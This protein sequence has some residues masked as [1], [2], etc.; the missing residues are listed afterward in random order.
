MNLDKLSKRDPKL[1]GLLTQSQQWQRLDQAI[2]LLS[3]PNLRAH[4][5]VACIEDGCLV[6]IAT[7]SMAAG[8]LRMILPSLLPQL[9]QVD[10]RIEQV[11][12]K[13]IPTPPAPPKV[14]NLHF[15]ESAL[16]QFAQTAKQLQ[17]HPELAEA[18]TKL[19]ERNR[20]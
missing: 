2:K 8:R 11:R 19:V 6:L 20:K 16:K 14:K 17:H 12:I 9:H 3:P 4:F 13:N 5:Q 18:L 1:A 7:N 10:H 15:S